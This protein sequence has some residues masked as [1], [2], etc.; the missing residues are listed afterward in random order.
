[1]IAQLRSESYKWV[2]T[3]TTISVLAGMVAL[4]A[5]AILVHA[6]GLPV[7]RLDTAEQQRG[8]LID[9]GANLGALFSAL[10]G[11]LSITSEFRTGTIRPTLLARPRRPVVLAAKAISALAAGAVA[12][13]LAAATVASVGSIG[14]ATRGVSVEVTAGDAGRLA[15]GG[16][17][18]GALWAAIGLG[19]GTIVRAQV[20]TIVGLFVWLLFVEN[21][22]AGD[23]PTAHQYAPGA[24]AQTLAGSTRDA[25]LSSVPLAAALLAAYAATAT[26]LGA[27]ALARRDVA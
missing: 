7:A 2:T 10:L 14:L 16:L 23:L 25:V 13:A 12:G 17:V 18:A 26:I 1:M 21:L 20:P 4:I 6:Y 8:I 19:V 24:L 5:A 3:R 9:V 15:I 27:T 22:L 11:A